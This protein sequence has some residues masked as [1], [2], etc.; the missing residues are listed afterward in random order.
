MNRLIC[1]LTY[2]KG[3]IIE[4]DLNNRVFIIASNP[5]RVIKLRRQISGVSL[6]DESMNLSF[7]RMKK[8]RLSESV[9]IIDSLP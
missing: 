6:Y 5:I 8:D 1:H 3:S 9:L 2:R 4:I 7:K